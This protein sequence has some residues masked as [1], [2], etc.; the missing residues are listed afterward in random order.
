MT[1]KMN[2]KQQPLIS[3]YVLSLIEAWKNDIN[4]RF[5]KSHYE[6]VLLSR[7]S[8]SQPTESNLIIFRYSKDKKTL[9][10]HPVHHEC[11]GDWNERYI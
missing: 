9:Q 8:E 2:I 7:K 5:N 4:G 10:A 6:K 1:I 11:L 3:N